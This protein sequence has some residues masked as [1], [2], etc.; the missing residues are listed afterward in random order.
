M[1]RLMDGGFR[2]SV[3]HHGAFL[4]LHRG[5][6]PVAVEGRLDLADIDIAVKR[7]RIHPLWSDLAQIEPAASAER[8]HDQN[9]KKDAGR[10]R[11]G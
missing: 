6:L 11:Q 7:Q 4:H 9:N 1:R 8:E 3:F 2:W 5:D 10:F